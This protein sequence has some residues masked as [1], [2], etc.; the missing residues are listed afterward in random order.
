MKSDG[1]TNGLPRSCT[2]HKNS[3]DGFC[4]GDQDGR[5]P[6]PIYKVSGFKFLWHFFPFCVAAVLGSAASRYPHQFCFHLCVFHPD[7]LWKG[8]SL[9]HLGTSQRTN[10]HYYFILLHNWKPL[11]LQVK[12]MLFYQVAMIDPRKTQVYGLLSVLH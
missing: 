5:K 7:T 10:K 2:L 3:E 8:Q 9:Q 4:L 11:T 12:K 1:P 6:V